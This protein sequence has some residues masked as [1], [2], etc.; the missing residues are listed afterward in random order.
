MKQNLTLTVFAMLSLV[1]S[2]IHIAQDT[3][4]DKAGV[5]RIGVTII[6]AIMIG[7]LVGVVMLAGRRSGYVIMLL[8]GLGSAYMPYLHSMGPIGTAKG[9][10]FILVLFAMG[11]TGVFSALLAGIELYRSLGA[12]PE[13]RPI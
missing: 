12:R 2:L 5:D 3:M 10:D 13:P 6:L 8:G 7:Y 9:F 11:V 1:L 4:F